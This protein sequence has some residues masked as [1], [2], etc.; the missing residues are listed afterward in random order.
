[1][2]DVLNSPLAT[3][4]GFLAASVAVWLVFGAWQW[5]EHRRWK[6]EA[7]ARGRQRRVEITQ[8]AR[9]RLGLPEEELDAH[10]GR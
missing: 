5:R 1:M 6:R 2:I 4:L 10:S 3:I 8:E 9:R 7:M